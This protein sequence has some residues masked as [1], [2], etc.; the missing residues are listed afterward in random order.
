MLFFVFLS[1][2]ETVKTVKNKYSV[3]VCISEKK[4]YIIAIYYFY[5][6]LILK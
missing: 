5:A 1:C 2:K 4:V 6:D 3:F